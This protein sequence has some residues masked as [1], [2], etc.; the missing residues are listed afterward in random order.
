MIKTHYS[1]KSIFIYEVPANIS[2]D[3]MDKLR[4][5]HIETFPGVTGFI[6]GN[7]IKFKIINPIKKIIRNI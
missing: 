1:K 7:D 5:G 4:K 2:S 3:S 6:H